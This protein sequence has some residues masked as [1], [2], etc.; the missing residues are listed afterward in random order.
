MDTNEKEVRKELTLQD[1]IKAFVA[2]VDALPVR[3][4]FNDHSNDEPRFNAFFAAWPYMTG[5]HP[6]HARCMCRRCRPRPC[7]LPVAP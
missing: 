1:E 3:V 5:D 6:F 7:C 2:R 4:S